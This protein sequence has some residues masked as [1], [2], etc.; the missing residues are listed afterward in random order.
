MC[1]TNIFAWVQIIQAGSSSSA[2]VVYVEV[3]GKTDQRIKDNWRMKIDQTSFK[4][5]HQV[6]TEGLQK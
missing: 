4:M 3:N 5:K 1:H 6:W 2:H